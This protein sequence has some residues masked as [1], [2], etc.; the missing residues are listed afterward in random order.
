[1]PGRLLSM[2]PSD[3]VATSSSPATQNNA[4]NRRRSGRAKHQPVLF[5][6]DPNIPQSSFSNG[7]RK[8]TQAPAGDLTAD[9][10]GSEEEDESA[11]SES[12]PDEEELK[13]RRRKAPKA[14][15]PSSKPA[16]KKPKTNGATTTKLPVRPASN[17]FKKP[18][19][20]KKSRARPNPAIVEDES[21]LYGNET[22]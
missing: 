21:G 8:R 13:E 20:P 14:K 4:T 17:G 6:E 10:P 22:I 9:E 19:A 15:K 5:H 16:A 3:P 2:E 7:K 18:A 12:D 11:E 1:M